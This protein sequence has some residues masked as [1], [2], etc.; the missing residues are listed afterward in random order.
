[1]GSRI[2]DGSDR[3]TTARAPTIK[4]DSES[5]DWRQATQ[6]RHLCSCAAKLR[7]CSSMA[8]AEKRS[9]CMLWCFSRAAWKLQ[10]ISWSLSGGGAIGS[11]R[12][13]S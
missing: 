1:M 4:G 2:Q 9:I 5:A 13:F 8:D 12:A 11:S 10:Q 3:F 7:S 6:V